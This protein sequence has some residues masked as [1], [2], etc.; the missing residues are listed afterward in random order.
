MIVAM[1]DHFEILRQPI[2]SGLLTI[3]DNNFNEQFSL[4]S[5]LIYRANNKSRGFSGSAYALS[6]VVDVIVRTPTCKTM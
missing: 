4:L 3:S 6:F 2:T 5:I 1:H